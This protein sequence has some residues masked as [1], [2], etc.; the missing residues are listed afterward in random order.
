M[1]KKPTKTT[2]ETTELIELFADTIDA[3]VDCDPLDG[4]IIRDRKGRKIIKVVLE[5]ELEEEETEEEDE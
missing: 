4:L 1:K 3:D 5:I 2:L